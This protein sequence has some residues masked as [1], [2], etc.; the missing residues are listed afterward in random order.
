[1]TKKRKTNGSRALG[2][3]VAWVA[4]IGWQSA[5]DALAQT[6]VPGHAEDAEH[7]SMI[8]NV[9][10]NAEDLA[11][12]KRTMPDVYHDVVSDGWRSRDGFAKYRF[13]VPRLRE[14][15]GHADP[16]ASLD[17]VDDLDY[18]SDDEL[19]VVFST[20]LDGASDTLLL[21]HIRSEKVGNAVEEA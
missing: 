3:G 20:A 2:F 1:M 10:L 13:V 17:V 11:T 7:H 9:E 14:E 16:F 18:A 8:G 6:S 21:Q 12:L 4:A 5:G 15:W 19:R